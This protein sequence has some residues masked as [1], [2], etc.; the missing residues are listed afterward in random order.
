MSKELPS[1]DD[2]AGCQSC[3]CGVEVEKHRIPSHPYH[4]LLSNMKPLSIQP[5]EKPEDLRLTVDIPGSSSEPETST[6]T[7]S[8]DSGV[9][10]VSASA[11][12]ASIQV[13]RPTG[14]TVSIFLSFAHY[15]LNHHHSIRLLMNFKSL[16]RYPLWPRTILR[17]RKTIVT[18][19]YRCL[20]LQCIPT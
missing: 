1:D 14:V 16:L 5:D 20:I 10:L 7:L 2:S 18:N 9:P 6:L 13:N 3:D 19:R 15:W 12:V 8:A 4:N 11:A 17:V